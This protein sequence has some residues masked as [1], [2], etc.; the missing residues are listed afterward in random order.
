MRTKVQRIERRRR[1]GTG[2]FFAIN[3]PRGERS[4]PVERAQMLGKRITGEVQ[5]VAVQFSRA[6]PLTRTLSCT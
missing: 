6:D 3:F 5:Q 4:V 1:S 2:C